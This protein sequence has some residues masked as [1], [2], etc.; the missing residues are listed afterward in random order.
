MKHPT[1][2]LVRTTVFV[3]AFVF[4]LGAATPVAAAIALDASS[5][6]SPDAAGA[7]LRLFLR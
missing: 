7:A 3:L 2:S 5:S 4:A 1:G 6:R